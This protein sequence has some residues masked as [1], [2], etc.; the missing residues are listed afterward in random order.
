[1]PAK[2]RNN[3]S[4]FQRGG[5]NDTITRETAKGTRPT[6]EAP[7]VYEVLTQVVLYGCKKI[8]FFDTNLKVG[9]YLASL[10][11]V[12]LIGDFVPFPRTY[13][14]RSD[15]LFNVYFVKMGWAWTLA[16]TTPFLCLSSFVICCGDRNRFIKHHLT[17]L[18]VATA[19]WFFW[20]KLFNVIESTY[21]RCNYKGYHTKVACLKAGNFWNGFDISGHA[22]ILIYS[23]LVLI[24]EARPII[25]WENIKNYLRNEEYNRTASN[26][27]QLP[28]KNL[29]D[30]EFKNLKNLYEKYTPLIRL[31]FVGMTMLQLLW[32]VMLVGTMLYYHKMIEKF[33]SGALAIL[34]WFFTY[35][36]WYANA[37]ILPDEPGKGLFSY[38]TTKPET[39]PLK[40]KTSIVYKNTQG[41]PVPKF[42]G[43]PLYAAAGGQSSSSNGGNNK[44]NNGGEN[45]KMA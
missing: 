7:S 22:F 15:N 3:F 8:I 28:L 10:F 34:S 40:R 23:S 44:G 6:A 16:M 39:L 13:L 35:R 43:M 19:F 24:E 11:L 4:N 2:P 12:S 29:S 17:R 14:S 42:M 33:I 32:D 26:V 38:Q 21:G 30:L 5:V 25:G 41:N 27:S 1:M 31:C 9:L 45:N 37:N 18:F 36:Y 20:T